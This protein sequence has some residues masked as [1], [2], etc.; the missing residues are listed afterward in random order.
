VVFT[1]LTV[2]AGDVEVAQAHPGDPV[3]HAEVADQVV[4]ASLE[5]P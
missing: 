4:A 2:R 3:G 1:E 5:A